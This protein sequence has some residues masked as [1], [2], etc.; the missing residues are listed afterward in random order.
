MATSD[1]T[2]NKG[3]KLT[4]KHGVVIRFSYYS[5]DAPVTVKAFHQLL[6]FTRT[7]KHARISGEE[8]W[9]D[10]APPLS[11]IQENASIFTV[12]G[13]MLYGPSLPVRTKTYNC[14]GIYYGNGKGLDAANIF[15]CVINEDRELL[16]TL[17]NNIWLHGSE[18]LTF[19]EIQ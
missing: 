19:S 7:F 6:P 8:I 4:S 17:G 11:I 3:F 12:P 5:D 14:I 15:A 18:E 13:E 1:Y 10:E 2:M 9:T 16:R